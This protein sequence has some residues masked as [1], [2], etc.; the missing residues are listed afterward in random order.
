M[1]I[2]TS[3]TPPSDFV[4]DFPEYPSVI[5][6]LL[7][8]RGLTS[9]ELIDDFLDPQFSQ[10]ADP[11][12][13]QDM[14]K[15]SARIYDAAQ[16][17]ELIAVYGDYDA[18][19]V[20]G[21]AILQTTLSLL[22]A[23]VVCYIPHRDKE[24]YGLNT[25]AI[26]YLAKQGA[27]LIITCD[28]GIS[29]TSEVDYAAGQAID[30]IVTDHHLIPEQLPRALAIIHPKRASETYPCKFLSGGGVAY[31]LVRG[32]LRD[33]RCRLTD[34]QKESHEKW[35]LDL[36]A[37]ATVADMVELAGENRTIVKFGLMVLAK[38]RRLGMQELYRASRIDPHRLSA[39]T[40][41]FQ[42]APRINAAGRMDHAN[43]A[44]ALLTTEN[45]DEAARLARLIE[46]QNKDRQ[47]LTEHMYRVATTQIASQSGPVLFFFDPGWTAGLTGLLASRLSRELERAVFVMGSQDQLIVGSGRAPEH[48]N[49]M[50]CLVSV[51]SMLK[52][53]GGHPQACGY[54]MASN[55]KDEFVRAVQAYFLEHLD[56]MA[57]PQRDSYAAD[58]ILTLPDI[59]WEFADWLSKFEPY[60]QTNPEPVFVAENVK[61]AQC[62]DMGKDGSHQQLLLTQAQKS[63][64]AVIFKPKQKL[65]RGSIR[66]I[67]FNVRINEWNGN[68]ELRLEVRDVL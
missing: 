10:L 50:D 61:I 58:A 62:R 7:Y 59:T 21:A 32:L 29:N 68:R 26:D 34:V 47:K 39:Q 30:V 51:K 41:G 53:F 2:V 31:T 23:K 1:K 43:T 17:G 49:I 15:A 5:Q 3:P 63:I 65:E 28:C 67:A 33:E 36:V 6:R 8:R 56:R 60:G 64:K 27:K 55:R 12:L 20:C 52:S 4:R 22:S 38:G 19:G 45:R 24:G 48:V 18:D 37:I 35:L 44:Y 42:I 14:Q 16:K 54:R 13:F 46:S 57:I 25:A 40:I 66:D 11:F 9:Q